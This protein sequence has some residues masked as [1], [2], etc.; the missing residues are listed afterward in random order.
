MLFLIFLI[1]LFIAVV[2]MIAYGGYQNALDKLKE[3]TQI[4][5]EKG[6]CKEKKDAGTCGRKCQKPKPTNCNRCGHTPCK[7]S[8]IVPGQKKCPICT[9]DLKRSVGAGLGTCDTC[10]RSYRCPGCQLN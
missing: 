1:L 9:G 6:K 10:N 3:A 8:H 7:C 4:T 2:A 5:T